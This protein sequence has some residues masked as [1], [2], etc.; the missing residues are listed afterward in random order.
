MKKVPYRDLTMQDINVI[1]KHSLAREDSKEV[2]RTV[3][4]KKENGFEP[5]SR[6]IFFDT[7]MI[8]KFKPQLEYTL[9]QLKDVHSNQKFSTTDSIKERYDNVLW[10]NSTP[11]VMAYL[12]LLL[13]SELIEPLTKQNANLKFTKNIMPTLGSYDSNSPHWLK[14]NK[15]NLLEHF[16][17]KEPA[18]D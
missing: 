1:F 3:L 17:G 11:P 7:E 6:P 15:S 13:A 12:H 4:F 9:G 10:A 14:V 2:I 8:K 16:F 18:D 5:E